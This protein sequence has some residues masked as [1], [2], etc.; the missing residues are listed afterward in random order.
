MPRGFED[1]KASPVEAA[2]RLRSFVVRQDVPLKITTR[3]A[4]VGAIV[5]MAERAL[6]LLRFGWD[7]VDEVKAGP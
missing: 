5:D 2:L 7:A 1:L 6:P 4:L 3:L